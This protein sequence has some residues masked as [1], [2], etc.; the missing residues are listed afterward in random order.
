MHW[1]GIP[2]G[3][4][5]RHHCCVLRRY[6]SSSCPRLSFS[7]TNV[8][9]WLLGEISMAHFSKLGSIW[10]WWETWFL[11]LFQFIW[12]A[13]NICLGSRWFR[14]AMEILASMMNYDF[15]FSY[16]CVLWYFMD[17]CSSHLWIRKQ[18]VCGCIVIHITCI[19]IKLNEC[20]TNLW[21]E[22]GNVLFVPSF[23]STLHDFFLIKINE[24]VIMQ[25]QFESGSV[26]CVPTF[27]PLCLHFY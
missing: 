5:L 12:N 1:G 7:S 22:C 21:F 15:Y 3:L 10:I 20:V 9:F 4:E 6:I 8:G 16:A 25:Q 2:C 26:S 17:A 11:L 14:K 18:A 24:G 23:W 13:L 19:S 27:D